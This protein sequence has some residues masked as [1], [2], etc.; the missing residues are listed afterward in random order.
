M[1]TV[2]LVLL[3]AVSI[4]AGGLCLVQYRHSRR[5][6]AQLQALQ[7]QVQEKQAAMEQLQ[8]EQERAEQQKAELAKVSE[9]FARHAREQEQAAQSNYI[10][11]AQ[12]LSAG[13][14]PGGTAAPGSEKGFG[15]MLSSMMKDPDMKKFIHDQQRT[16]VD[17]LYG[18]LIKQLKLT[19][20]EGQ[21]FKDLLTD[22]MMK[23]AEQASSIMG[24]D[25]GKRTEAIKQVEAE[26][27]TYY[28]QI[29]DLLGD[30]RYAQYKDFQETAGERMQLN[31][32]KQ[33]GAMSEHPLSDDQSEQLLKVMR[34]EKKYVADTQ[35]Q[36][37]T[38]SSSDMDKFKAM[39]SEEDAN[40]MLDQQST[41][42]Q[43][44]YDRAR[45][46]LS[47]DQLASFAQWQTNQL[48]MM[49]MGVNMARKMMGG[50]KTASAD[51]GQGQ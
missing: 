38:S 20:D 49:R 36:S 18:P 41:V 33:Q 17:Q 32:W 43:R 29:K 8:R 11:R 30:T 6:A 5:E 42:N 13:G 15:N 28:D 34:E 12:A 22:S 46:I 7:A 16:M 24:G 4:G 27:K 39:L 40:K 47:D 48:N 2:I 3:L 25:P 10:A 21:K 9:D 23:G 19:P 35:G 1:K 44:V 37:Q 31:M 14:K 50:D 45:N 51:S 26:Q